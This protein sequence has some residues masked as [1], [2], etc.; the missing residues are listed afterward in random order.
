MYI[1]PLPHFYMVQ[2]GYRGV[3]LFFLF[4]FQNIDCGYSLEAPQRAKIVGTVA[5]LLCTGN[6]CFDQNIKTT[7]ILQMKF[8]NST[9]EKNKLQHIHILKMACFRKTLKA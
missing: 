8:S 7:K 6:L 3:Y 9:A 4:C 2:L 5:V 1:T